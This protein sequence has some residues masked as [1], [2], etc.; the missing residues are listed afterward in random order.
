MP[1]GARLMLHAFFWPSLQSQAVSPSEA[2]CW[3]WVNCRLPRFKGKRQGPH[4]EEHVGGRGCLGHSC[5]SFYFLITTSSFLS[6]RPLESHRGLASAQP[7]EGAGCWNRM[8]AVFTV[9]ASL[10]L[11]L[12]LLS[13][14]TKELYTVS[15]SILMK[16]CHQ[17]T[18]L[19]H[20]IETWGV[21]ITSPELKEPVQGSPNLNLPT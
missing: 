5:P 11:L 13:R 16:N 15:H 2:C 19:P 1:Q 18:F 4:L 10:T 3:T 20:F 7:G 21:D 9:H 6:L 12:L 8:S 14:D 17:D